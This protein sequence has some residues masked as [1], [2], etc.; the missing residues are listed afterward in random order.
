MTMWAAAGE[1]VHAARA[2]GRLARH[3][4]ARGRVKYVLI[5][6]IV[7]ALGACEGQRDLQVT[8]QESRI[9][10]RLRSTDRVEVERGLADVELMPRLSR[11]I[12]EALI[13][14]LGEPRY[15]HLLVNDTLVTGETPVTRVLVRH[16]ES[17]EPLRRA[18]RRNHSPQVR[19]FAAYVLGE[20]RYRPAIPDLRAAIAEASKAEVRDDG[21]ALLNA[22]VAALEKI[23]SRAP[24][25]K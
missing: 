18:L 9:L 6:V 2:V 11:E 1:R 24:A 5:L 17:G 25:L 8:E 15:G 7:A 10:R 12:I 16:P 14:E 23:E 13:S 21:R 4:E 20:L 22:A 19:R 3:A